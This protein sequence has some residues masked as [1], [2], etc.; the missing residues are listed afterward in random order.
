MKQ[1]T[2]ITSAAPASQETLP[3]FDPDQDAGDQYQRE[4]IESAQS[5]A[6]WP[7]AETPEDLG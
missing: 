4:A 3:R 2:H 1:A 6:A 7:E 5:E